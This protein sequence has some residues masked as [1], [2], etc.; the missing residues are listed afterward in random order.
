MKLIYMVT[1]AFLLLLAQEAHAQRGKEMMPIRPYIGIK[2]GGNFSH[3][4]GDSWDNGVQANLLGG[5]Y[6]GVKGLR[7][8]I[9][10]EALFVQSQYM[11]ASRFSDLYG[12]YYNSV[13]DSLKQGT[14]RVNQL[15]IPVLLQ[16]KLVGRLWLQLGA[17]YTGLVSV[18]DKDELL[19]DAKAIFRSS[20]VAGVGGLNLYLKPLD[21]GVR[22]VLDF[23]DANN[24]NISEKWNSRALQVH[25]GVRL[26]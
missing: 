14:F 12:M 6:A 10:A 16:F 5:V 22:Y 4:S 24:T 23:S 2:A 3:I 11:T 13:G 21:I 7:F 20:N 9:Q 26:F 18:S 19:R 1:A 25:V 15:C 17:Q 8:G